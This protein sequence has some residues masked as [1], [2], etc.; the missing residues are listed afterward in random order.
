[1]KSNILFI[2]AIFIFYV[3]NSFGQ[4]KQLAVKLID[5]KIEIDGILDELIWNDAIPAK[6]FWQY[7]P[8]DTVLSKKQTEI[9]MLYDDKYL[10]IGITVYAAGDNYVIPSLRR[11]YSARGNDNINLLFDTF[12]D[13]SN[14][15]FFG[16]NPYGVRREAFISGGGSD[17]RNFNR[18]WDIA[19]IGESK[20]YDYYYTSE[21]RI[22]LS[23][24]KFKEGES[25]WRFNS[26][27]F[28]TQSTEWSTWVKVPQNQTITNLAFM[29]DMIFENPLGKSRVPFALIPY[30]SSELSKDFEDD[31]KVS[32]L[33]F[34][35]D[36]K[37]PI[38]NSLNLDLTINPD[39]SQVEVDEQIV[40]LTRFELF[41][42]EKRQFFIDNSDLFA[43]F[44]NSRE[45]NP[46]FSRR[47]GIASD[48]DDNTI[49][50]PI[51]AGLRLSGKLTNDLRIGILNV[52]TQEDKKNE[53]PSNNNTVIALQQKVF[54]RSNIGFVFVN[55]QVT[56]DRDFVSD[57]ANYNRV[58]GL[59][60]N[61]ASEDN[62][63]TGKYY[64]HKSFT[65]EIEG[66]DFSSGAFLE[67]SKRKI[68]FRVAGMFVGEDFQSDLGFIRRTDIF[69]INPR[70]ETIFYPKNE[71]IN[72]Y[73]FALRSTSIWKPELDFMNTDYEFD[74]EWNVR[75]ENQ[76]DF[77]IA[78]N[79]RY[80]FL[81]DDF[82]PTDSDDGVPLPGDTGY[83]FTAVDIGYNSDRRKAFTYF[84]RSSYGEFFNGTRYSLSADVGFRAQ[85]YFTTSIR[86]NYNYIELPDPHPTESI[87][88]IGPRFDFTFTK[89]LY[90][91]TFV[92]YSTQLD[93]F[94]INS[95][96]Q[97]RFKPLSD[98]FIVYN[99]N[100]QTTV[101]SP[102]SRALFLKFTYWIN[103]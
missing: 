84:V 16:I 17:F 22:P 3:N 21:L 49:E 58:V 60:F 72:R 54:S 42:P 95:R 37:I 27:R 52:Q 15:F 35:G 96:V 59:D 5:Q 26:Y 46:F 102:R 82:D 68:N 76:T 101:F 23:S 57:S 1:M 55:R 92:Q 43:D 71:K 69:K 99:D 83:N 18:N 45:A 41:L 73:S 89:N 79:T 7:F 13:G 70:I 53:I 40:N 67:Y 30:V 24:F 32:K 4:N 14:A 88:L 10:Y 61:L 38:G 31:T 33:K 85:P 29:G 56:K 90:W 50:N 65:S 78:I 98:L 100:Y 47:I 97:W 81:F 2:V 11:D 87:W 48:K 28:D 103:I 44:G 9:K 77:E 75:L 80:I 36:A 64:L 86:I 20:I 66:N 25:K 12:N 63:W 62:T 91:S 34:G 6:D 93:N 8:T 74:L 19:W 94:S 39:F 51:M